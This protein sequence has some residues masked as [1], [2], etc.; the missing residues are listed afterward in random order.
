MS[1]WKGAKSVSS[2]VTQSSDSRDYHD[3]GFPVQMLQ[4]DIQEWGE[5]WIL[6][7]DVEIE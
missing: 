3:I 5:M 1:A 2:L 6:R 4:P 7:A